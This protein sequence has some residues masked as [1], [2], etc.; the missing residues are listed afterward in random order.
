M[1]KLGKIITTCVISFSTIGVSIGYAVVTDD[2][3]IN[4]LVLSNP[5]EGLFIASVDVVSSDVDSITDSTY[6]YTSTVLTSSLFFS[7]DADSF[8]TLSVTFYNNSSDRYL[9]NKVL[10]TLGE[11]TYDNENIEFTLSN[12]VGTNG[13]PIVDPKSS[14]SLN[15]SFKYK[16]GVNVTSISNELNSILNFSFDTSDENVYIIEGNNADNDATIY[17]GSKNYDGSSTS[18]RWTS[19]GSNGSGLGDVSVLSVVLPEVTKISKIK[20]YH[21]VDDYRT[22][23][24]CSFPDSVS[25]KYYN[26][27]T[28]TYDGVT[29]VNSSPYQN[30][31]W[32]S[33]G[34]NGSIAHIVNIDANNDKFTSATTTGARLD[35]TSAGYKG[36]AP[37]TTI[38]FN[39]VETS[40]VQIT[41]DAKAGT[42]VGL[43]EVEVLDSNG[44][45]VLASY[46]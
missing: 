25:A 6:T 29:N 18:Y 33:G 22:N 8:I 26:Q 20:L 10:Y 1:N 36:I 27:N 3:N 44:N 16:D 43:M 28:G 19:W 2:L 13:L 46:Q 9:F 38:E 45:N 24:H 31:V 39:E 5:P 12:V 14:L 23:G 40:V 42:W 15:I 7:K 37:Y 30:F 41:L 32:T 4:G 11:T 34:V 17:D 21:F 35:S